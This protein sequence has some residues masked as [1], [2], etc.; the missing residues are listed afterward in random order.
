MTGKSFYSIIFIAI[1]L[2]PLKAN[3]QSIPYQHY[4]TLDGLPSDE[5]Y[6]IIED[7]SGYIWIGTDRGL[8]RFDGADFK[9]YHEQ[10][11]LSEN[12][13]FDIFEAEDSIL[14]VLGFHQ[15]FYST[16]YENFRPYVFNNTLEK[17]H[18]AH[19]FF[20]NFIIVIEGSVFLQGAIGSTLSIDRE[21]NY[22]Y[23][24]ENLYNKTGLKTVI[25]RYTETGI[26]PDNNLE[27]LSDFE[28]YYNK[29]PLIVCDR[30]FPSLEN[31]RGYD[32]IY[33]LSKI[34]NVTNIFKLATMPYFPDSIDQQKTLHLVAPNGY[35]EWSGEKNI[36]KEVYYHEFGSDRQIL[37]EPLGDKYLAGSM[38]DT[39]LG[40]W[41]WTAKNGIYHFE[42]FDLVQL[43][44]NALASRIFRL[45]DSGFLI[46]QE[47]KAKDDL[48]FEA[49]NDSLFINRM[50]FSLKSLTTDE[51]PIRM[52][53]SSA[54]LFSSNGSEIW[55]SVRCIQV[56]KD[57]TY[58]IASNTVRKN[59]IDT[60]I[61]FRSTMPNAPIDTY[62]S[63]YVENENDLFLGTITGLY[64]WNGK[65]VERYFFKNGA[66]NYRI[67]DIKRLPGSDTSFFATM[68]NGIYVVRN[69]SIVSNY[70]V[71]NSVLADNKVN[72][73][74]LD[75]DSVL[76]IGTNNGLNKLNLNTNHLEA[77]Q[78]F[79]KSVSKK[80]NQIITDDNY[81]YI[82]TSS[83][84]YQ[85]NKKRYRA[86]TDY[87]AP[88]ILDEV[89]IMGKKRSDYNEMVLD[90][91]TNT[92]RIDYKALTH[93]DIIDELSYHYRFYNTDTS[94]I[95]TK[96]TSLEFIDLQPGQYELEIKVLCF[97]QEIGKNRINFKFVI[98]TPY[99]KTWWFLTLVAIGAA[100][101]L[102]ISIR[103]IFI[104]QQRET[105]QKQ[106]V[107]DL[108]Q[109]ALRSQLNS[110]FIYNTLSAIQHSA[111]VNDTKETESQIQNFSK[112]LR[113]VF[114]QS[115]HKLISVQEELEILK[116]YVEVEN[117]RFKYTISVQV[118]V[119]TSEIYQNAIPPLLLQPLIENAIQHGFLPLEKTNEG[120]I[121][122][123]LFKEKDNMVIH[124]QDNGIGL[125]KAK[126]RSDRQNKTLGK[127]SKGLQLVRD[128]VE[129]LG[130]EYNVET[131]FTIEEIAGSGGTLVK[132][133]LPLIESGWPDEKIN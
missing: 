93:S 19:N 88:L 118:E 57:T 65:T 75:G 37:I 111:R 80:I 20:A 30:Y 52:N 116:K 12:V 54:I 51:Q 132:I 40:S 5:V 24:R 113:D 55:H 102:I 76:W 38:V 109:K 69:D 77:S 11:G 131:N 32:R 86:V 129:A 83:G 68:G 18:K 94:W 115:D 7:R 125:I 110:H 123:S 100:L 49:R 63:L 130:I 60:Q 120:L 74:Y 78:I 108:K 16:D 61:L 27:S 103:S 9:V 72:Q 133:W 42:N 73:L 29:S 96:N 10:N 62:I 98:L 44:P 56:K 112:L 22:H 2:L 3:A 45:R 119:K 128:R 126:K 91:Q 124:I 122:L 59:A 70:N 99:W 79:G 71:V 15:V 46:D 95:I 26:Y 34:C 92:I 50:T 105:K 35:F 58:F 6:S 23:N 84:L 21:G 117:F 104:R 41:V 67:E 1:I 121:R 101:L 28:A 36:K 82:I 13:I 64:H 14:W 66:L 17:I 33:E 39:R 43:F 48:Y 25:Q 31:T 8:V 87:K 53:G 90:H 106:E 47:V 81:V 85:I 89:F 114:E 4:T 107:S 97:N 127:Q